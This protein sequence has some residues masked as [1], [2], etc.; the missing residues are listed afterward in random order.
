VA[1]SAGTN[2]RER[3]LYHV[4]SYVVC[5]AYS[6]TVDYL[7]VKCYL[8]FDFRCEVCVSDSHTVHQLLVEEYLIFARRRK[9]S[10]TLYPAVSRIAYLIHRYVVNLVNCFALSE[11]YLSFCWQRKGL[12]RMC[13]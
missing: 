5:V 9:T 13:N 7:I 8:I 11:E 10:R 4:F 2:E 1:N 12:R 6:H 3:Y